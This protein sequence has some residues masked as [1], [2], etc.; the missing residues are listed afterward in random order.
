MA[1]VPSGYGFSH[2][3]IMNKFD[4]AF[5]LS[6]EARLKY[7]DGAYE[8]QLKGDFVRCA[9]TRAPI[10]LN[11]L[12]YWDVARQEAYATAAIGLQRHREAKG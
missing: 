6:S 3:G 7:G 12:K 8:V 4:K 11:E 5:G 10:P 1:S 9:I 2:G